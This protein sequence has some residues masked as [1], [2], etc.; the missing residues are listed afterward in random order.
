[1]SVPMLDVVVVLA[2]SVST[3]LR[4]ACR[5]S[6]AGIIALQCLLMR[7]YST[8]HQLDTMVEVKV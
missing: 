1:M 8:K 4:L 2:L 6:H 7:I 5:K 3:W